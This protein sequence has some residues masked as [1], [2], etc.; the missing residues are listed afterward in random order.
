MSGIKGAVAKLVKWDTMRAAKG[1]A[2]TPTTTSA[3]TTSP[4]PAPGSPEWLSRQH[5]VLLDGSSSTLAFY[6]SP[7][8]SLWHF[9][10]AAAL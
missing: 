1:A 9:S 3:A 8:G 4:A 2:V 5:K 6:W 10:C 7:G